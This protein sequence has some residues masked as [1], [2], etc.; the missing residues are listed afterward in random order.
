MLR[1]FF[2]YL[3]FLISANG[4]FAQKFIDSLR[5]ELAIAKE[6]TNKAFIY[7]LIATFHQFYQSDSNAYYAEK[8]KALSRKLNFTFGL[9]VAGT[10]EFY[11]SLLRADYPK[12]LRI[13]LNNLNIARSMSYDSNYY[14]ATAHL[15]LALVNRLMHDSVNAYTETKEA[16]R[17]QGASGK[18]DGN[19]WGGPNNLALLFKNRNRDSALY[20]M[21]KACEMVKTGSIV[22]VFSSLATATLATYY[23]FYRNYPEA[24]YYYQ[25]ALSQADYYGNV[26]IEARVYMNLMQYSIETG[27]KDSA[28]YFGDKALLICNRFHYGDYASTVTDSLSKIYESMGQPDSALKYL[29]IMQKAKDSIFGPRQIQKFLTVISENENRQKEAE[30]S[31]VRLQDRVKL[32]ASLTAV[33]VFILL[34]GILY[35]NNRQK[36]RSYAIIRQQKQE[37]DIQKAKVEQAYEDLKSTQNQLIHSEKMASLGEL[38]AG[39]AHEI[40]NPLNFVN[41]FSEVNEELIDEMNKAVDAGNLEEVRSISHDVKQNMEKIRH[42]GKRADSIVK[43]MLQHS[44]AGSDQKEPTDLNALAEEWLR[45]AYHGYRAKEKDFNVEMK[46]DFDPTI[47]PINIIPQDI[48]RTLLNLYN[49]AFYAVADK[50]QNHGTGYEPTVFV[51]TKK[52]EN[53]I[54]IR[55]RDNGN[56]IPEKVEDKVFQP[57]FTTKPAGQGTGLGLSLSYDIIM[58]EHGGTIQVESREGEFTNLLFCCHSKNQ[59]EIVSMKYYLVICLIIFTQ[60]IT[61]AQQKYADSVKTVLSQSNEETVSRAYALGELADYY[62][63]LQFDSCLKYASQTIALSHKLNYLYGLYSGYFS[64]FHGMNS[65]GNYYK[66]LE[67]VSNIRIVV[68]QLKKDSV[69]V[70]T[71]PPYFSGLLYSETEDYPNAIA[72]FRQGLLICGKLGLPMSDEYFTYSQLGLIYAKQNQL[73]SALVNAKLG[74]NLGLQSRRFRKY[75]PLA[76]GALGRIQVALHHYDTAADLFRNAIELSGLNNN[77]YFQAR[78]YNNL[79]GLFA[80]LNSTDSCIYYAKKSLKLCNEHNFT[81]IM[82][83]ASKILTHVYSSAKKPDSALKYMNIMLA[84]RDSVFSPSKIRQFQQYSFNEIKRLEQKNIEEERSQNRIRIYALLAVL[85]VSIALAFILFRNSM[86]KQKAKIKIE[87]AYDELKST[88]AQLIQS[89]KMASLG[90][91]TAGI[92]H[93]IQNPLNF[94]N[95]FSEVNVEL[96]DELKSNLE[97]GKITDAANTADGIRQNLEKVIHH[98]QRADT[99]VKGMLQHSRAG[100]GQKEPTDLNVLA[101]EWLRLAYHGYRAKE[102]DFNVE[103]KTDFDP[104]LPAI[105]IIPQDIGRVL[106]NMYNNAFYSLN[107]KVK[108]SLASKGETKEIQV[109]FKPSLII[110]TKFIPS[111]PARGA[112]SIEIRIR[113]NGLGIPE[114]IREKIF[115]PFFT[116]KPTGQGTG[117]GLSLSYDIITK[118]HGGSIMLDSSEGEYAEFIIQLPIV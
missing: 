116:S 79:A 76:I 112:G 28:V 13:A 54:E 52:L 78:N 49:N 66:A 45:L 81:E 85:L 29:K 70:A 73:D 10:S 19:F 60:G 55:I 108:R 88:Q 24:R 36:Q 83:D 17:L 84:A 102:K 61:S 47:P 37:T 3:C 33:L 117:L 5:N 31:R 63:F 77:I 107:E 14:M 9:Y 59:H 38:T 4:V 26:Y 16:F 114:K 46:T 53:E 93:E 115:Q 57:F 58:K 20:Y 48:G 86:Q 8:T 21:H 42:H 41:N 50:K 35:A 15:G 74:F 101:E 40:Q 100:S 82:L 39:I 44:R 43:G 72:Q 2:L 71:T 6:D 110:N 106:L 87:K 12:A 105:N 65:Q 103:M 64:T 32:Y 92:A 91:L 11:T 23:Q 98:G 118:E 25:E 67:A 30:A 62:G 68:E 104:T 18:I 95:N 90:E 27:Q 7:G 51:K 94:V 69:W 96:I 80:I 56:G 75:Y 99:I 34:S 113:D 22:R 111:P 89:E 1:R 109:R 97:A